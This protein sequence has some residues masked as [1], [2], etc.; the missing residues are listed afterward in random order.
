MPFS[1]YD[2]ENKFASA[3]AVRISVIFWG[4]LVESIR[5]VSETSFGLILAPEKHESWHSSMN[6]VD[7]THESKFATAQAVGVSI[8]FWWIL[9]ETIK[10]VSRTSN[11][12]ILAP[13]NLKIGHS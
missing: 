11:C 7:G 13:V 8:F 9:V 6:S 12:L 10:M 4:F 1:V 3:Q 5:I 2:L